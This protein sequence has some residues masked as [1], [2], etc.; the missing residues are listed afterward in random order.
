MKEDFHCPSTNNFPLKGNVKWSS[1]SNI[2]LVKYWGKKPIQ[3][4]ANPSLSFTLNNCYTETSITFMKSSSF[5]L[6]LYVDGVKNESFLQKIKVFI[7]RIKEFCPYVFQYQI[8]IETHN[9]FPHSSG[10]ASSA[11]G[12]SALA[13]C[14]VSIEKK[15]HDLSDE[16]FYKKVSFISR[17]GSGSASRSIYGPLG[18]WGE[19]PSFKGSSN[20]YAIAYN[21]I[22]PIFHDFQDTILLVDKGKKEI[23]STLGHDLM[24]NHPYSSL[25][26]N[27]A[28]EHLIK[29]KEILKN[30]DL[31]AFIK[32]VEK[33][34]LTLH[35]MMMTSDPYF[36]LM[37]PNTLS[38][39]HKIWEIRA[40]KKL[41]ICIT[42]DAGAN[43]HLLYPKNIKEEVLTLIQNH[44]IVYCENEQ[45]I[46]D[47]VGN[48]PKLIMEHYA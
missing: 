8:K 29:L 38:I 14:L 22:A 37:K 33:E 24:N 23:S 30:G 47:E 42:L 25:R 20:E 32:L 9:T 43:V 46:C 1:P 48:G 36:I 41:P 31:F 21:E 15:A 4:P 6:E 26:Y 28:N 45:Y 40:E 18:V 10:I 13:L 34:A 12:L 16:K 35:S 17:L 19:H 44:L 27:Q 7:E 11:S 3:I 39:I 2:A 5:L